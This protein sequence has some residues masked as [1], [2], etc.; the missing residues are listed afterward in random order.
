MCL[1]MAGILTSDA[2][3]DY[4]H[5][6]DAN[7]TGGITASISGG[8]FL[9]CFVAFAIIDK[10]GRRTTVQIACVLFVIGAILSSASVDVAMLIVG[11]LFSGG[12]VGKSTF[13]K[14]K[15]SW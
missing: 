1:P 9:G 3:K 4:F 7:V 5:N 15:E 10:L 12:G 2:F 6:P 11:R 13:R 14:T 8:S